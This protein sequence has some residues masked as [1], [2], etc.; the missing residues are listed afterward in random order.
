MA[1]QRWRQPGDGGD[2]PTA[3]AEAGR[4]EMAGAAKVGEAAVG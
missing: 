2:G 4:A 1:R 3:L